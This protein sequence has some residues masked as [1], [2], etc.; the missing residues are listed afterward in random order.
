MFSYSAGSTPLASYSRPLALFQPSSLTPRIMQE[1]RS[2]VSPLR[3][4]T[5]STRRRDIGH[6]LRSATGRVQSTTGSIARPG[7]ET[8]DKPAE[9]G[10]MQRLVMTVTDRRD[11]DPH[12][13]LRIAHLAA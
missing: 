11:D 5:C 6:L 2:T 9:G 12:R 13:E 1:R 10:P 7:G 4:A 3:C 8:R